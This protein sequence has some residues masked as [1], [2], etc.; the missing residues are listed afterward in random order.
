MIK[1]PGPTTKFGAFW[2][3]EVISVCDLMLR[4][5]FTSLLLRAPSQAEALHV[6][7]RGARTGQRG[8]LDAEYRKGRVSRNVHHV[9][10]QPG[11]ASIPMGAV[12]SR[13]VVPQIERISMSLSVRVQTQRNFGT[14][15]AAYSCR[16]G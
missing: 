4:K 6:L 1:K 13:R 12:T 2:A 15:S 16:V 10:L 8:L 9:E 7:Q 14:E 3:I 5:D 11:S